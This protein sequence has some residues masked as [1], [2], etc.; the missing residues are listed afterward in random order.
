[1]RDPFG[2]KH[3]TLLKWFRY[4]KPNTHVCNK[5]CTVV[6]TLYMPK[7][8]CQERTTVHVLCIIGSTLFIILFLYYHLVIISI[9]RLA[10]PCSGPQFTLFAFIFSGCYVLI[11]L[12]FHTF[13]RH[14]KRSP[15]L[16]HG[17]QNLCNLPGS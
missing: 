4:H 11:Q 9:L 5:I 8:I 14:P 13:V 6:Y 7:Y 2:K 1:M 12:H 10:S 3:S 17:L 16:S 15:F